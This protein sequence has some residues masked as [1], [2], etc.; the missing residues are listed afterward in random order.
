LSFIKANLENFMPE[1][2]EVE[3]IKRGLE[4][5]ILGKTVKNVLTSD[6]K[7]RF[8]YPKNLAISLAGQKI[9]NLARRSKYILINL[10]NKKILV[11]HLGMSGRILF[12]DKNYKK[13][14]KH[15]HFILKFT[16]GT[17]LVFN[18]PRRFGLVDV[19]DKKEIE[20]HKLFKDLGIE[21][22]T[23]NFNGKHLKKLFNNKSIA[24]KQ[25]IMDSHNLVGVGNIYASESLF[26]TKIN[27]RV[28]ASKIDIKKLEDLSKNIQIVL[29]EA[30]KAG[31]STLKDYV[32]S[33]GDG[34]Y[35]Q[36][37]FKVYGR[38]NQP[39]FNCKNAIKKI[40][41]QGRS[42]YFCPKCQK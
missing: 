32:G 36:H 3:T 10:Q 33:D 7:L 16:D 1:L 25:A 18:D 13:L 22:L 34:G 17:Q 41:Q 15:D 40:T 23:T 27:P 21:P 20:S 2:P 4:K 9:E 30:I 28:P 5:Q 14:D 39:C 8:P 35:F 24:I 12:K 26:R 19:V 37:S 42:T 6:K 11:I 31:G 29:K 38:E